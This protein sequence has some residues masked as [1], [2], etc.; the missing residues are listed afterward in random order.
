MRLKGFWIIWASDD[1]CGK[2][3]AVSYK[4]QATSH[5]LEADAI[6]FYLKLAA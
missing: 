1:A 5:K 6:C 4:L 2:L 3:L